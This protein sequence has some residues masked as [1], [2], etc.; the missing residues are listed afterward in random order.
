MKIKII[1]PINNR[2]FYI[3]VLSKEKYIRS[4]INSII[5]YFTSLNEKVKKLEDKVNLHEN[6]LNEIYKEKEKRII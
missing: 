6:M 2:E 4:E 1:N 5:T 3:N